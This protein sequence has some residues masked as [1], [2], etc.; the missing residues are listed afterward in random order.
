MK[1]SHAQKAI[2]LLAFLVA[3]TTMS[4]CGLVNSLRS[5]NAL[6]E[7]ARAYKSGDFQEAEQHFKRALELSP[8]TKNAQFFVA[9]AIHAQYR[10]GVEAAPNVAKARE[11][12]AAYQQVL[13]KDPTSD[14]AYNAMVYLYRQ[15]KDE[16]K[17]REFLTARATGVSSPPDKRSQAMTV[18]AS[19]EWN[20]SYQ[21]TEQ[22]EVKT[23]VKEGDKTFI[24][25]KKPAKEEDF[26]QAKKCITDGLKLAEQAI[27]LDA[28]SE[29]AWSF[30][31]NLLLEAVKLDEMENNN[32][33]KAEHQKQVEAAQKRTMEL[34]EINRKKR[35]AEEE[36][37]KAKENA[38]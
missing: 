37:A 36:K 9:R 16:Q 18:L 31:T 2:A 25:Y 21:I 1:L 38:S 32:D 26:Q 14:E 23:N 8:D 17:E 7:G 11:A 34:N 29:Q 33:A 30:K 5:K 10:P 35:D 6:N 12:I 4:G 15:I 27:S 24:K 20:C 19:K 3:T 13:D 28:N 22:K